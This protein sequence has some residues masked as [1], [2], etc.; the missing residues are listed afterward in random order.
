MI[1]RFGQP[2]R[3]ILTGLVVFSFDWAVFYLCVHLTENASISNFISRASAIPVSFYLQRRFT[4]KAYQSKQSAKQWLRFLVLWFVGTALG[5]V[6]LETVRLHFGNNGAG[7]A[8]IPLEGIIAV[9]NYFT[10]KIWV[11]RP[12]GMVNDR[13]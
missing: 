8:K 12:V 4:F 6:I 13:E 1:N 7:V 10:M 9:L 2:I 3:Y 5:A 11:Y